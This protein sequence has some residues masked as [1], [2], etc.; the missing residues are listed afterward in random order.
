MKK[1]SSIASWSTELNTQ[2][3]AKI[4]LTVKSG[5]SST[6]VSCIVELHE[7]VRRFQWSFSRLL[8]STCAQKSLVYVKKKKNGKGKHMEF[9]RIRIDAFGDL[10]D[11]L[12]NQS[13]D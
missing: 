7:L 13:I 5:K 8:H 2:R 6:C 4:L 1:P 12:I 11:L 3:P 10:M 9:D